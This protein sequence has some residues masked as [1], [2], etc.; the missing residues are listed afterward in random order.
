MILKQHA[1]EV[2]SDSLALA[3]FTIGLVDSDL[4]YSSL[5]IIMGKRIEVM[6]AFH[7][8]LPGPEAIFLKF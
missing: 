2:M 5:I 3:V 8:N 7:L 6:Y 1:K 4:Y